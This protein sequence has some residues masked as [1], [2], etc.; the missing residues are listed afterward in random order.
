MS[1]T[2]PVPDITMNNGVRIPQLGFGVWQI[3]RA[4]TA[5]AVLTAF[6]AGYRHV[7][8]AQMY[9]NEKQVGE[10]VRASGLDRDDLFVTTKLGNAHHAYDD[11]LRAFERSLGEM[12]I[13]HVDLFLVH[14][15]GRNSVADVETWRAMEETYRSG[16]ARAIGVSNF[17]P[18]RLRRLLDEGTVVPAADQIEIH[19]YRAQ[20]DLRAFDAEHDI[21]TE[22]W[23]PLA[24]GRVLDDP[25][26]VSIA[27]RLGRTPAQVTLRWH[28][29]RGDVVFPKSVTP[30]RIRENIDIFDFELPE[31]D[32]PEITALDKG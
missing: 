26:I 5:E 3:P 20:D 25:V 24:Q 14:W 8:T 31:P 22:A 16:R 7:D 21:V 1:M 13:G 17:E 10:A 19:P 23:S 29:Q 32:M 12:D 11:A 6:E 4:R 18:H 27:G 2:T 28:I 30:R 9:G 15:P